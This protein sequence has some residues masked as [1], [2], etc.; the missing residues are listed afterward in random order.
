MDAPERVVRLAAELESI[1]AECLIVVDQS[2]KGPL[3]VRMEREVAI[4]DNLN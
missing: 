4:G 2:V 1:V 3:P